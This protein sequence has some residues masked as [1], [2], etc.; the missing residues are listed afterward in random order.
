MQRDNKGSI[1]DQNERNRIL[2]EE[3]RK[4]AG[5]VNEEKFKDATLLLLT[6]KGRKSGKEYAVPMQCMPDGDRYIVFASHQGAP[7]DPDWYKNLMAAGGA[8]VEVGA[9][10]FDAKADLITGAERDELYSRHATVH[11]SFAQYEKNT[12]R[13]IPVVALNRV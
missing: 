6:V 3:F 7:E 11:P 10:K 13:V 4:N 1:V 2:A 5:V 8:M 9:E 12:T